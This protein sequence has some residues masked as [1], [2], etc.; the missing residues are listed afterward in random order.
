MEHDVGG[1]GM[2]KVLG[3]PVDDQLI[4]RWRGW[5]SPQYQPFRVD[6]LE[7]Q[8]AASVPTRALTETPEWRDTF[9]MYAGEWT[10][11]AEEEFRALGPETRWALMDIRR[12]GSG[13]KPS[14]VW[15]SELRKRGDGPLIRWIEAGVRPSRHMDVPDDVWENAR[16]R[17]PGA[18][19]LSGTY[20]SGSGANC[21]ATVMAAAGVPEVASTWVK[22]E[23]FLEWLRV[24]THPVTGTACDTEPGV[25]FVW[26]EHEMIA[27]A[28]ISIGGGWMLSKPSQCWN[29]P[30]LVRNLREDVHGWRFP[31]TRVSRYQL[32]ESN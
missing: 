22:P 11:L 15:P 4:E 27:H 3:I 5:Y 8:L 31:G 7:E 17:L 19:E 28:A 14:P 10:W 6:L 29:S 30:R 23:P 13:T 32:I 2:R 20:P 21:Y 18:T 25:V 24:S 9:F 12:R 1:D 16:R 26:T